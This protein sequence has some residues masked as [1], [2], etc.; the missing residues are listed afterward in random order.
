MPIQLK[1][2]ILILLLVIIYIYMK[3]ETKI[4]LEHRLNNSVKQ[5]I[6]DRKNERMEVN[7]KKHQNEN[8][9]RNAKNTNKS[10]PI[11]QEKFNNLMQ[12]VFH[13]NTKFKTKPHYF[14]CN[15]KIE[16]LE[17]FKNSSDYE[18]MWETAIDKWTRN[19]NFYREQ[20]TDSILEKFGIWIK[21]G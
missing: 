15:T 6:K 4:Q 2:L 5:R 19:W 3:R 18:A 16:E 11:D 9:T 10:Y 12:H 13:N 7:I 14:P 20:L 1:T 8:K 21:I 17:E